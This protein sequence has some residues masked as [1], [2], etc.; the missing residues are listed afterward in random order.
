[1]KPEKSDIAELV[2]RRD[3]A[4]EAYRR[5]SDEV[6]ALSDAWCTAQHE[7][8]LGAVRQLLSGDGRPELVNPLVRAV[9]GLSADAALV[10][11]RDDHLFA[12][13]L[14]AAVR[15][16]AHEIASGRRRR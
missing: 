10:G 2:R 12:D 4:R 6:E 14:A 11:G 16:W 8:I 5:Y 15:S 1:M 13:A 9:L 3:A 7:L